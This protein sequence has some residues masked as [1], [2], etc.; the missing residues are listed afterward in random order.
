VSTSAIR[1]EISARLTQDTLKMMKFYHHLEELDGDS[2]FSFVAL[3]ILPSDK[4]NNLGTHSNSYGPHHHERKRHHIILQ[5]RTDEDFIDFLNKA[6][7]LAPI[8]GEPGEIDRNKIDLYAEAMIEH[9]RKKSMYSQI[10]SNNSA[11]IAGRD[12]ESILL[13]YPFTGDPGQMETAAEGLQ[14]ASGAP[15]TTKDEV[16]RTS[17]GD[18][19]VKLQRSSEST[20]DLKQSDQLDLSKTELKAKA[21]KHYVTIRVKDYERL[22]P[23][24]WLND[25]LVDFWMQW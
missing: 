12:S 2:S 16:V 14:E 9:S 1:E 7:S 17:A 13:V 11:F 3:Q 22:D 24:E 8:I 18:V 10:D 6:E 21:R 23:E 4:S 25:S 15:L 20:S 19:I 5:F